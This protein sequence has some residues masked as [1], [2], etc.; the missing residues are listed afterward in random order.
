MNTKASDNNTISG[1]IDSNSTNEISVVTVSSIVMDGV[2]F[3]PRLTTE[4]LDIP[5]SYFSKNGNSIYYMR[6]PRDEVV[7]MFKDIQEQLSHE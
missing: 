3:K 7:K 6:I 1:Y 4:G 2:E 5:S